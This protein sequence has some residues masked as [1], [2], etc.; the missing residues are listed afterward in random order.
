MT[1]YRESHG[2]GQPLILLHGWGMHS[3]MFQHVVRAASDL[4]KCIII[5]LPG[6][7]HS[8]PY[9]GLAILCAR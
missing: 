3:G 2:E 9:T 7:G 8:E 1:L 6:H 4:A 5:D